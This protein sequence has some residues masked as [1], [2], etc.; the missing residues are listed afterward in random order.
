[1]LQR[2][3]VFVGHH[4]QLQQH[5]QPVLQ[6][7]QQQHALV[8]QP[9]QYSCCSSASSFHSSSIS[10][11][12]TNSAVQQWGPVASSVSSVIN[13]SSSGHTISNAWQLHQVTS[14]AQR[15]TKLN[16]KEKKAQAKTDKKAL[17]KSAVP[18]STASAG[19]STTSFEDDMHTVEPDVTRLVL[20]VCWCGALQPG[21]SGTS[22]SQAGVGV[23]K[24]LCRGL[25]SCV[26]SGAVQH[27]GCGCWCSARGCT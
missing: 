19:D 9:A 4:Q 27:S 5:L 18:Q 3:A 12:V 10:P 21:K 15:A 26:H 14:Y 1:M 17:K 2:L 22:G 6:Q 8:Q 13:S 7:L 20:Q 16:P 11:T 24:M 23:C 25:G